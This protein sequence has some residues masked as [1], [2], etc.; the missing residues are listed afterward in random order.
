MPGFTACTQSAS[1]TYNVYTGDTETPHPIMTDVVYDESISG[2]T[3]QNR[4]Q[5][6]M[7]L[8]GSNGF[9]N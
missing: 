7:V 5:C 3:I 1:T 2:F 6:G 9:F 8:L 4:I